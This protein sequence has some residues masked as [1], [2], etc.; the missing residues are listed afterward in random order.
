MNAY[1]ENITLFSKEGEKREVPLTEG[2]N[3]ITG[4]SKTGKSA[5]IEIVDYCLFSSRSTIPVGKITNFTELFSITINLNG[6]Y[7]VIARPKWKSPNRLK[8]YFSVETDKDRIKNFTY[9]FFAEKEL[10]NYKDVQQ[11][12]ESYLGLAVLDTRPAR[13]DDKRA[14]GKATM[15]SFISLLFQHQTLIANKHTLFYRF[16][17]SEKRK[18]T[19]EQLPILL[20]WV[21]SAYYSTWQ[22]LEKKKQLL[23]IEYRREKKLA[24][25]EDELKAR[26]RKPLEQYYSSIG[27]QL[28]KDLELS[29]LKSFAKDLP[30]IPPS[31][32]EDSD[33]DFDLFDLKD[34]RKGY[35]DEL[36]KI[37]ML[38]EQVS[39]NS[40][41]ADSYNLKLKSLI[42]FNNIEAVTEEIT[43]PLCHSSNTGVDEVVQKVIDSREKLYKEL[44]A[45]SN[46][47]SDSTEHL[48]QLFEKKDFYKK[49]IKELSI[50]IRNL[51]KAQDENDL[52]DD[53]RDGLLLLKGRIEIILEQILDE[54]STN[55]SPY[56][57]EELKT[58]IKILEG[59]LEGYNLNTKYEEANSFLNTKMTSISKR[60]D[61][62]KELQPGKMIFDLRT[63]DF[64]YCFDGTNI[65]L[66][67]MGSGAN[68]LA[69][70][71]SLFLSFLHLV[72]K[73]E[74]SSIPSILFIDQPS[75]VYFPK[76]SKSLKEEIKSYSESEK[77]EADKD[78]EQVKK[79]FNVILEEV[80]EIKRKYKYFPQVIVLEHADEDEFSSYVRKRWTSQ[81]GEKLI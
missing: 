12:I 34:K 58:D 65:L 14:Y 59:Q 23:K 48:A 21:D 57:I 55:N 64:H 18:K 40:N 50:Q 25:S 31:V 70:H 54:M 46:Y 66:S 44:M 79:F 3:I 8:A 1:I 72:S 17:D 41:D 5:L 49:N 56:S 2:L 68:W 33:I 67:E 26:L 73:E 10:R 77:Q 19:I 15:R 38:I 69:C 27:Y 9:D 16:E 51:E 62:E 30:P 4:D 81:T 52:N 53:I 13:T 36:K 22:A 78:I 47:S 42:D 7:L 28:P 32:Y 11:D 80:N 61:F 71:L 75:Q 6:T 76:V 37:T 39:V 43:C 24:I 29:T 74:G 60:L 63:F 45:T 20:G 35:S